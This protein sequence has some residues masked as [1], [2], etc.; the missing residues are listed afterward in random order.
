MSE[1]SQT[2]K[3]F[4]A[5]K[6]RK[7]LFY[8]DFFEYS[9]TGK[10]ITGASYVRGTHGP[11]P[12][13]IEIYIRELVQE[14]RAIEVKRKYYGH[15]Q[16]LLIPTEEADLSK[17]TGKEMSVI[18]EVLDALLPY[19]ATQASDLSHEFPGWEMAY[20]GE[21]IPYETVFIRQRTLGEQEEKR[22]RELSKAS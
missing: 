4:S 18:H 13:N 15:T 14:E 2:D 5:T 22:C 3:K 20:P 17:F 1:K 19:N 21:P 11:V 10:S 8:A 9:R 6:L 12:D 16:H 7:Q